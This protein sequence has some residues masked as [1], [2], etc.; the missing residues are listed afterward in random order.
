MT[1]PR[2]DLRAIHRSYYTAAAAPGLVKTPEAAFLM[3]DGAGDPD[4]A[5]YQAAMAALY[6][7]AYAV[8]AGLKRA[9]ILEYSVPPLQGLWWTDGAG[10]DQVQDRASWRWT[11]MLMQPPQV[12]ADRVAEAVAAVRAKRP[13]AP[14]DRVRLAPLHEGTC[15]QILHVGPYREEAP[16]IARLHRFITEID[17]R[18]AGRHHE[19]YLS[20]PRRTA[21][22]KLKTIIRY[23]V[24][25]VA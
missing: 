13:T 14:V 11:M 20:D 21:P 17:H 8:R 10:N 3:I 4:G 24:A 25:P 5:E 12:D 22:E 18:I 16:T 19:I 9:G 2:I 15:A 23:P 1:V 7:V 6:G